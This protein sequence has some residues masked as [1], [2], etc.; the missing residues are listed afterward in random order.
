MEFWRTMRTKALTMS[1]WLPGWREN[2]INTILHS[3]AI[4]FN[5]SH[6]HGIERVIATLGREREFIRK[7][8]SMLIATVSSET[9]YSR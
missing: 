1:Y 4:R 2:C 9:G 3:L 8:S 7:A 6:K 5:L